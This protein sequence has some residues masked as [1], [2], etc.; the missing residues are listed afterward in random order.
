MVK[1]KSHDK[2][3]DEARCEGEHGGKG[4]RREVG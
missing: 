3:Q 1:L 2:K 4:M